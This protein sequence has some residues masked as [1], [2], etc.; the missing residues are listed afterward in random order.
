MVKIEQYFSTSDLCQRYRC[1]SRTISRKMKRE[2]NPFPGPRIKQNGS[3]N[4]W[5]DIDV[6][7]WEER[8]FQA[9]KAA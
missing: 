2:N 1:S 3:E 7:E 5:A 4:L 8:E 9:S 6:Y